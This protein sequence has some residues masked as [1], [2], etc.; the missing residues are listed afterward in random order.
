[1]LALIRRCSQTRRR[2]HV[3][4]QQLQPPAAGRSDDHRLSRFSICTGQFW[5]APIGNTFRDDGAPIAIERALPPSDVSLN[6]PDWDSRCRPTH[7]VRREVRESRLVP[8]PVVRGH[9]P[10]GLQCARKSVIPASRCR[11][12]PKKT[13]SQRNRLMESGLAALVRRTVTSTFGQA[14]SLWSPA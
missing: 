13:R 7:A 12:P 3:V 14:I 6:L 9:Q 2:T 5:E 1:M 10:A 4:C 11:P 8:R